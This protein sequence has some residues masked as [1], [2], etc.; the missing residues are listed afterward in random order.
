VDFPQTEIAHVLIVDIVGFSALPANSQRE[1]ILQFQRAIAATPAFQGLQNPVPG[2]RDNPIVLPTGSGA[3]FVFLPDPEAPARCAL[4]LSVIFNHSASLGEAV[5]P[6]RM[7]IHTGPVAP[8][9]EIEANR[10]IPDGGIPVAERI[11]R[12][13]DPGH[14]LVSKVAAEILLGADPDRDR[15]WA[16]RLHDLGE[17]PSGRLFN[18]YT[19]QAGNPERPT[20]LAH[21]PA[22]A[23]VLNATPPLAVLIETSPDESASGHHW[24]RG[25]TAIPLAASTP[26][27]PS[28]GAELLHYR[29]LHPIGD[30]G[31]RVFAA[32][33]TLHD[34]Q[35]AL[36]FLP[37]NQIDMAQ[38][39]AAFALDHPNI[40][41]IYE[42]ASINGSESAV[43]EFAAMELLEGRTLRQIITDKHLTPEQIIRWAIQIADALE[44]A[45]AKGI[46]HSGLRPSNIF[47][48]RYDDVKILNFGLAKLIS[49]PTVAYQSPE[50]AQNTFTDHRSD[51]FSF[52]A[53][54]Y[55]LVTGLQPFPGETSAIILDGILHREPAPIR[56][57]AAGT[58]PAFSAIIEHALQK[59]PADRY[60]AAAAIRDDLEALSAALHAPDTHAALQRLAQSQ[61]H[62]RNR[63]HA[64]VTGTRQRQ[65]VRIAVAVGFLLA[66]AL[67]GFLFS[68]RQE[69][70]KPIIATQP[71]PPH[72][73]TFA[74]TETAIQA[75]GIS[76]NGQYVAYAD[77]TG[78]YLRLIATGEIRKLAGDEN[79]S[80]LCWTPDSS[81]ILVDEGTPETNPSS[82]SV[83]VFSANTGIQHKLL[84]H[85]SLAQGCA[86]DNARIALIRTDMKQVWTIGINGEEPTRLM[87]FA[88]DSRKGRR[89]L[90]TTL[91]PNGKWLALLSEA[92][93]KLPSIE[94]CDANPNSGASCTL[95]LENP[96]LVSSTG[97]ANVAWDHHGHLLYTLAEP[98]PNQ[99]NSRIWS[100]AIGADGHPDPNPAEY[101]ALTGVFPADLSFTSDDKHFAFTG[102]RFTVRLRRADIEDGK[103]LRERPL[104][105]DRT[106]D[107][108][109]AWTPDGKSILSFTATAEGRQ[110]L[111]RDLN[112]GT[113]QIL[114]VGSIGHVAAVTADSR[115]VIYLEG[116]QKASPSTRSPHPASD[117]PVRIVRVPVKGGLAEVALDH[118]HPI[119][120][121]CAAIPRCILAET[122]GTQSV[123]SEFDP[124]KGRGQ[125]L[126]RL[127]NEV[128]E[129]L[130]LSPNGQQILYGTA[131]RDQS[132]NQPQFLTLY[133]LRTHQ[134]N[135]VPIN[136]S[137]IK[138]GILDR[139]TF[140]AD[141]HSLY[142]AFQTPEAALVKVGLE[143]HL[144]GHT[145]SL[146]ETPLGISGYAIAPDGKQVIFGEVEGDA[147][148]WLADRD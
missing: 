128:F 43:Y 31:T 110:I 69:H 97:L 8:L 96:G 32:E 84:D 52:G 39:R 23:I 81:H 56:E 131:Q 68:R 41:K 100:V 30:A 44:A 60:Q 36:R 145:Q 11:T 122:Q 72:Q 1:A 20:H 86:A 48:T 85:A 58:P 79:V 5:L 24:S 53:I 104:T 66:A 9:A 76:P 98:P 147:N 77:I 34:C 141:G 12:A 93:A 59:N 113:T 118:I 49:S 55:E 7:G 27:I 148:V 129:N 29:L 137:G 21:L 65:L 28:L 92:D 95:V 75:S 106:Y 4:E 6:L 33:D 62:L 57:L 89:I 83:S 132:Q 71:R 15:S 14:I 51:I 123:I 108:P 134:S 119:G 22:G 111:R 47:I 91:S 25:T 26:A 2:N 124:I 125:E 80:T 139:V 133:D 35:V 37:H 38:A 140:A 13:G 107:S 17:T 16:S 18:L 130:T 78:L 70:A 101:L 127:S 109:F 19:A 45:H 82:T 10:D 74:R 105:A 121:Y 102:S 103:L 115:W 67:A 117:T 94:I 46:V 40:C 138:R 144:D 112:S 135:T 50:Q 99:Y 146:R 42:I 64:R 88:N 143:G 116:K 3:A 73:L 114:A 120:I 90:Q 142:I 63:T 136:Q 61:I 54:L 126:L 87:D